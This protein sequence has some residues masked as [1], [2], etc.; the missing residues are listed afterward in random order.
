VKTVGLEVGNAIKDGRMNM[1]PPQTQKE[2]ANKI[3][4]NP[5]I[6]ATYENGTAKPEQKVLM[7]LEKTLGIKLRGNNIGKPLFGPKK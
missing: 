4:L 1:N 6:L 2:L 3:S 5:S 7:G